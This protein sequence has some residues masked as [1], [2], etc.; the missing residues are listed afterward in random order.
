VGRLS[1]VQKSSICAKGLCYRNKPTGRC[2]SG[3]KK[4]P[5]GRKNETRVL[6]S[7]GNSNGGPPA[8]DLL[9]TCSSRPKGRGRG[10]KEKTSQ[11]LGSPDS[12]SSSFKALTAMKQSSRYGAQGGRGLKGEDRCRRTLKA[13]KKLQ[14]SGQLQKVELKKNSP[15]LRSRLGGRCVETRKRWPWPATKNLGQA[16]KGRR[17]MAEKRGTIVIPRSRQEMRTSKGRPLP[18]P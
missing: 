12:F 18:A 5:E 14:S 13:R 9:E 1:H 7:G 16:P 15:L 4:R 6:S 17:F 8:L 11:S 2:Y 3:K 10:Q